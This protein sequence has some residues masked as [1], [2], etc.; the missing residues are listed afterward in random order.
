MLR[1]RRWAVRAVD[2]GELDELL[3]LQLVLALGLKSKEK[4]KVFSIRKLSLVPSK[5]LTNCTR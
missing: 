4:I 2:D 5:S 1:R 3:A